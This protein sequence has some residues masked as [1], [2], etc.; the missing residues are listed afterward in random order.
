[1]ASTKAPSS[2][3]GAY[4]RIAALVAILLLAA[5]AFFFIKSRG[6]ADADMKKF[7][8]GL[9]K[10]PDHPSVEAI[11]LIPYS[12]ALALIAHPR[13]IANN[14]DRKVGFF[15]PEARV[16]CA[17]LSCRAPLPPD[18][19][20][21]PVCGTEQPSEKAGS[22]VASADVDTD[23]DGMPDLWE[24]KHGLNPAD[25]SDA[26]AD[27]DEDGFSSLLEFQSGTNPTD[28]NSHPDPVAFLRVS[29][30]EAT[31]L[32]LVLKSASATAQSQ[33]DY[34]DAATKQSFSCWVKL[35]QEI[36]ANLG[37]VKTGYTLVSVTNREE[38]VDLKGIGKV[39]RTIGY[40]TIANG[41]KRIELREGTRASDT[42]Y[43]ITL[44]L[45]YDNTVLVVSSD[46]EFKVAGKS[47]HITKV[48]KEGS[49]VVIKS[50]VGKTEITIP[51]EDDTS[52]A[53]P[54]EPDGF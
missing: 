30:I 1:M 13:I 40:A 37:K 47:F 46:D 53:Q 6:A 18:A 50:T 41:K 9:Q 7:V 27:P 2:L 48:D 11:N 49:T 43:K 22:V 8:R 17:N 39:K 29:K 45:T 15:V 31:P 25:P 52:S 20:K 23:G 42:D 54:A 3:L 14:P 33:I 12:N 38:M 51:K 24:K 28:K 21:C 16:W 34:F 5:S 19:E 26:S 32:P 36:T 35:G 10:E 44:V 4:D